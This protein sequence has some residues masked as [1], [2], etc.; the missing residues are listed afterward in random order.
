MKR[1]PV[2][3]AAALVDVRGARPDDLPYLGLEHIE[4]GTGRVTVDPEAKVDGLV[5]FFHET[6][7]LFGKL[8]PYLA[9]VAAPG[10]DGVASTEAL[11]LRPLR[12]VD[13]DFL[14]YSLLAPDFI[15]R[16]NGATF[17]VKMPRADWRTVGRQEI[18]LPSLDHQRAIAAF[19]D[20]ETARIDALIK[21][22]TRLLALGSERIDAL[23]EDSL[24]GGGSN[25]RLGRHVS[26]LPGYAFPSSD[27]SRDPQ[28]VRLLRGVN[29]APGAI[30]WDEVVYWPTYRLQEVERF[31]LKK[32]DI[33]LGMDR[34]WISRGIRVAELK[35]TDAPALLLQRVCRIKARK[36]LRSKFL[37]M[38]LRSRRFLNY[39]EPILTGVSVPHISSE[40]IGAFRFDL[41]ELATQDQCISSFSIEEARI[42]R[43][44]QT[45]EQSID[46]LK[47]FRSALITAAVTGQI[48]PEEWRRHGN[49]NRRLDGIKAD[50]AV[51]AAE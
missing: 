50:M 49:I 21:K 26:I 47:E 18:L 51:E 13:R 40:Q 31:I 5:S 43:I 45:T 33:V 35:D 23:I 2:K 3:R 22:K 32:G 6:D 24:S 41:P 39:F 9:K 48:D 11:V 15:D 29:V 10:F 36:L 42:E 8:R 25:T 16:I 38:L 44:K 46:C 17:G 20:A 37:M 34:P 14:R 7:V 30:R 12:G 19:L 4:G 28:D 27:F 1:I